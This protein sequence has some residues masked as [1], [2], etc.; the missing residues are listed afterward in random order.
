MSYWAFSDDNSEFLIYTPYTP[1]PWINYLT[2]GRYYALVSQTGGGFSFFMDP[3]HH[4]ITRREQDMLLNDRPGRFVF[5]QDV[6]D[7]AVWTAGG[8]P[9]IQPVDDFCCRHGF[10]YTEIRSQCREIMTAVEYLVLLESDVELWR[11]RIRN[12][13]RRLRRLRVLAYQE[14]LLGGGMI[15]PIARRFDSF[16]NYATIQGDIVLGTKLNWGRRG[17][18]PESPWPHEVF[19]TATR[20][21]AQFWLDKEEF[22]GSYRDLS[23][24]LALENPDSR[25]RHANEVWGADLVGTPEWRFELPPGGH[26]SW[27]VLTGI[28]PTG[29]SIEKA[30]S[31]AD[32]SRLARMANEVKEHWRDRV[33]R[34]SISTPDE[35]LNRLCG[36]W[37]PY[38]VII[39]SQLSSAPSYYHASD[40]SPGFRDAMQD[41]FGLCLLEPG[42]AREMIIRLSS[43]QYSDGS[44]S[45]RAPRIDLPVERSEKSDLPLWISL[46]ALQYV[47]ETGDASIVL[48]KVPYVD[49]PE[50]PLLDHIAA[51]LQRSLNDVGS[52]G[53]PLIHYGDWNDA[54]DGLGGEGRGESVFLGQFLAFA[55]RNSAV[56]ARLVG[57]EDLAQAWSGKCDDLVEI[58]NRDCWDE[59]RFVRAFHDDGTVIGCRGNQEGQ[60][61]L[62]PQVW[63]V[64]AQAAPPERLRICMD[65]VAREL[66]TP[67]GIRCLA[68]P[69]S[70]QDPH[71]GLISRFPPGVK[72][73]GAVFSHAMAFCL[74][75]ELRLGRAD[76]AWNI[77]QKAN[78]ILRAANHPEYR[79]EPYVYSQ[80]V[81]GPETNLQGQGF[82][83]WLT[84][85]CSW[86]QYAVV[87]WMLGARA[88]VD[89]LILDPCIPASWR[90]F[91]LTRPYRGST[92]HVI[93]ENPQGKNQ[94]VRSVQVNG[95]ILEGNRIPVP[96]EPQVDVTATIE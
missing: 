52:H 59:D 9:R 17:E 19:L 84:G 87:N 90:R 15:D 74:V 27:E 31:L 69:Y 64:L 36:G 80:F 35:P 38:Q 8:N 53:L 45:H 33:T 39:K 73:N 5:V 62:N 20:S 94:G 47:R 77:L 22:I 71:V 95:R 57:R 68:P 50:A 12:Q 13:S 88:E 26:Q 54:L 44:A 75:A 89:G 41:A 16:F 49:G 11:I 51:G 81:A 29:T 72:E 55:L 60:L 66:E 1:R 32:T 86:M 82:H 58:L 46:A 96:D 91:E 14:W 83:H 28:A 65:T 23:E 63:A 30:R 21:P 3:A 34:V 76:R 10:G 7:G 56:L 24:P 2:N 37:T 79:V 78:P 6:E 67:Y 92:L 4:V 43:F 70:H 42:R 48:D 93:V 40:A 18:R 85:T 25:P 61:Y